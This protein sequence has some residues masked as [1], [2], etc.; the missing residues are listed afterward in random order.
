MDH[1]AD[2]LVRAYGDQLE[3][4]YINVS[5]AMYHVILDRY[6]VGGGK[7]ER[8]TA[9]GGDGEELLHNFLS[10]LLFRFETDAAIYRVNE[11][12]IKKAGEG[13][14]LEALCSKGDYDPDR[15]G[16]GTEIKAV[17]YHMMEIRER[18]EDW[19]VQVLFD[20]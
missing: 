8:I 11:M 2:V 1:T 4:A 6:D 20:I 19:M 15:Q 5:K 14:E 3:E 9:E 16:R 10:E 18:E 13:F 7:E 17:T 12:E